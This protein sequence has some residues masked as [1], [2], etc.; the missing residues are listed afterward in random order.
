MAQP[1]GAQDLE[2]EMG[3]TSEVFPYRQLR[4]LSFDQLF[5]LFTAIATWNWRHRLERSLVVDRARE[6]DE[7]RMQHPAYAAVFLCANEEG[8]SA[9][10]PDAQGRRFMHDEV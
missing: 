3:Q 10:H 4:S 5:G 8:T 2:E 7:W 9:G 6:C 1:E